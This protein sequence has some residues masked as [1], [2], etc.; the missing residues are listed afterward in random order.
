MKPSLKVLN[1]H[2]EVLNAEENTLIQ[3]S[4]NVEDCQPLQIR[5]KYCLSNI[6]SVLPPSVLFEGEDVSSVF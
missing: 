2:I 5:N 4:R 6:S 3:N 1:A